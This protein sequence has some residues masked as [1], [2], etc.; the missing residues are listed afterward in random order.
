M[1]I[2]DDGFEEICLSAAESFWFKRIELRETCGV[3]IGEVGMKGD[4]GQPVCAAHFKVG[5]LSG[6]RRSSNGVVKRV[7]DPV[8]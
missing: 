4:G 1:V 5:R 7:A 2:P 3:G 6:E 8:T